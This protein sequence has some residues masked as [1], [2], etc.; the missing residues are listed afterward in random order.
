MFYLY[1]I[2]GL[3]ILT[4]G[5][6]LSIQLANMDLIHWSVRSYS[7]RG[8]EGIKGKGCIVILASCEQHF[9]GVHENLVQ[10]QSNNISIQTSWEKLV[11]TFFHSSL[12]HL[13]IC[14]NVQS[15]LSTTT[16]R[17]FL[18]DQSRQAVHLGIPFFFLLVSS[19]AQTIFSIY[20]GIQQ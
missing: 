12:I 7:R 16:S 1:D 11:D 9:I 19:S 10:H 8:W 6:L 3:D 2:R 17:L 15:G 4:G 14:A 13:A 5:N 18:V 20:I